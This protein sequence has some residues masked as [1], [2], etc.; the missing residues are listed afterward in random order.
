MSNWLFKVPPSR[1]IKPAIYLARENVRPTGTRVRNIVPH[2]RDAF[3]SF[4]ARHGAKRKRKEGETHGRWHPAKVAVGTPRGVL[5]SGVNYT[6]RQV[7]L[8][9]EPS[10][11]PHFRGAPR[12]MIFFPPYC[13]YARDHLCVT[14]FLRLYR[15]KTK[16]SGW[17]KPACAVL[18]HAYARVHEETVSSYRANERHNSA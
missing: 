10:I 11:N 5:P 17:C 2:V 12:F 9:F 14:R 8:H 13:T 3:L 1:I 6:T 4:G 16:A 15:T 18:A 7:S